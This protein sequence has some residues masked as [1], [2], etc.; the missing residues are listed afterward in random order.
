MTSA[1]E[2]LTR[3]EHE[4]I[5]N[6]SIGPLE[7]KIEHQ[8]YVIEKLQ[9]ELYGR[10]SEKH[11]VN[12][13]GEHQGDLFAGDLPEPVKEEQRTVK[14]HR[15]RKPRKPR[16]PDDTECEVVDQELDEADRTCECGELMKD[17]G[18]ESCK[19]AHIIPA[20]MTV[21]E[22]R[23]HK[24]ACS[25]KEGG[26]RIAPTT[27]SAFPKTQITDETRANFLVQKFVDHQPYYR[28]SKILGRDGID[29]PDCS[30]SRYGLESAD[31]LAPIVLAMKLE[32][33]NANYLQADETTLPVLKTQKATPG[34]H[35]GYVWVYGAPR[36][37]IVFE[38][39]HGRGAVHP[40]AFLASFEGVL[41]TDRYKGYDGLRKLQSIIDV[42]C[43]AHVRRKF[44][45]ANTY[46]GKRT[47][48][49]LLAISK[50]Y[51]IEEMARKEKMESDARARLRVRE[52]KP[53]LTHLKSLL[54]RE[55]MRV[56]PSTPLGIA[57]RYA[58][59]SWD[60]LN[61]YVE[62]GNVEIDNNLIENAI[63]PIALGR[64]NYLFAGSE[65]GAEAAATIYSITETC[66]RLGVNPYTYLCDVFRRLATLGDP[67]EHRQLTPK[68]WAAEKESN[69]VVA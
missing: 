66:R 35:R 50:L 32:V 8:K 1:A 65:G 54:D 62:H 19:Q 2:T 5:L 38:Y 22:I 43:W 45:E 18:Y 17:I 53:V 21:R 39:Q 57:V 4:S 23:R 7:D 13:S 36:S 48:P 47:K 56:L 11:V 52:S 58:L 37:T 63:R 60:A 41:Q 49:I 67:E 6:K 69:P 20:R 64:K 31:A 42:A 9:R 26:V 34:A 24:Y 27:P 44:V 30:M 51:A 15:R 14:E 33:L 68:Q 10:K 55:R 25:C 61:R 40:Q 12:E 16:F 29:I 3:T 46:A 59:T 28:Q